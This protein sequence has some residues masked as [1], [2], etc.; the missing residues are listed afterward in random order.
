VATA[1]SANEVLDEIQ[2]WRRLGVA[3]LP[4]PVGQKGPREPD[5]PTLPHAETWR[6]ALDV[7]TEPT[8]LCVRTGLTA[9]GTR[10]LA[11]IDLDGK[12]PCDH[13]QAR[14]DSDV[15]RCRHVDREGPCVC[16]TYR[17]VPPEL[18]LA[19][20]RVQLPPGIAISQTARGFHVIF[21]V[22]K[23]IADGVLPAYSAD[24][25]WGP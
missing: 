7:A 17:G 19:A 9:D 1:T 20:L 6:I 4:G 24:V 14:H 11:A 22:V 10:C 3:V 13:D 12:C 15:G 23:P 21:W 5:W 25:F 18:A 2:R 16:D 8:N